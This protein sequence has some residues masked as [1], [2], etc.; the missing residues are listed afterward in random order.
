MP[1]EP[2]VGGAPG[3]GTGAGDEICAGDPLERAWCGRVLER[4]ASIVTVVLVRRG[5][6]GRDA[7]AT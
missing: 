3:D 6:R 4:S 2:V 7:G 5:R 1:A